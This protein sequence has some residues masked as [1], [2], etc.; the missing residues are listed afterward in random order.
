MGRTYGNSRHAF[1]KKYRQ[2]NVDDF[3]GFSMGEFSFGPEQNLENPD[4]LQ[5]NQ[6]PKPQSQPEIQP[7]VRSKKKKSKTA[8]S[9]LSDEAAEYEKRMEELEFPSASGP[10][11]METR[12]QE[13]MRRFLHD[14]LDGMLNTEIL[15]LLLCLTGSEKD[16]SRIAYTLMK[17]FGLFSRVFLGKY[18]QFMEY[19]EVTPEAAVLLRMIPSLFRRYAEE[20]IPKDGRLDTSEKVGKFL[21]PK[22]IGRDQEVVML[23]CLDNACQLL[24][25]DIVASGSLNGAQMDGRIMV[26]RA[27]DCNAGGVII[28]HNHPIGMARPSALDIRTTQMLN[29]LFGASGITLVDHFIIAGEKYASMMEMG[30]FGAQADIEMDLPPEPEFF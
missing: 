11:V 1:L 2:E 16:A 14:G 17:R 7:K 20:I 21:V 27:Y 5:E 22:F 29:N 23:L 25:C 24:W 6:K 19:P 13:L 28:A 8:K 12:K 15:E 18:E 10:I 9:W 3:I 4:S 26:Q 30:L